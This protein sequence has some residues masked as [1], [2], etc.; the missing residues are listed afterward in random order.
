MSSDIS[1]S[2]T[3]D[4]RPAA[5]SRSAALRQPLRRRI[6]Y[7][8]MGAPCRCGTSYVH[9]MPVRA[10][11]HRDRCLSFDEPEP[12]GGDARL[13]AAGDVELAQ[14][15]R[16]VVGDGLLREEEPRRDVRVAQALGDV[17]EDLELARRHPG[18][19]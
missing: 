14:D 6:T 19:V 5:S 13:T 3:W 12:G 2:P 17:G 9:G 1:S 16:D 10:P 11:A 7:V 8:S 4:E 18:G 15:R